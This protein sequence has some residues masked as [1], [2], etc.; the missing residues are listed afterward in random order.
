M[1]KS[2]IAL[3][4]IAAVLLSGCSK[5]KGGMAC[6]WIEVDGVKKEIC[7]YDENKKN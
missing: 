4:L 3:T 2:F 5:E 1:K 7:I 6:S